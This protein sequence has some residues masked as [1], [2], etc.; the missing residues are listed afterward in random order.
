MNCTRISK[1]FDDAKDIVDLLV[2]QHIVHLH[3]NVLLTSQ[4]VS[5]GGQAP[6][7]STV[8]SWFR[9]TDIPKKGSEEDSKCGSVFVFNS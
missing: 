2:D 9:T 6:L 5:H 1:A 4:C 8:G 7:K 3:S